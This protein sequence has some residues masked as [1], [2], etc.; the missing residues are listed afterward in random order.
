[1]KRCPECRRDYYDDSLLYC[2]DDGTTL[3]EGRA[4]LDETP[5]ALLPDYLG[6]ARKKEFTNPES[7]NHSHKKWLIAGA[8]GLFL[9]TAFGIAGY[10]YFGRGEARQID[11]IAVMPFLNETGSSEFDYLA[12]GIPEGIINSLSQLQGL[13]VMSRN[14]VFSYRGKE[15]NAQSIAKELNVRAVLTGRLIRQ[16]ENLAFSIELVDALDNRQIWGQ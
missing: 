3:L 1:M 16:G 13:K 2:L 5:T 7:R 15:L 9:L 4:A 12:D 6:E 11:S 10:L 8:I 14:S